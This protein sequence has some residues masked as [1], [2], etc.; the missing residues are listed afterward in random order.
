MTLSNLGSL[1]ELPSPRLLKE[2]YGQ[3]QGG[4]KCIP[5]H[6]GV[7]QEGLWGILKGGTRKWNPD[8]EPKLPPDQTHFHLLMCWESALDIIP[9]KGLTIFKKSVESL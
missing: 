3:D 6:C 8:P 7:P 4:S 5:W 9:P 2:E 1:S